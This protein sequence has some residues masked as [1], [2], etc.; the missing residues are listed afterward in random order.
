MIQ[1]PGYSKFSLRSSTDKFHLYYDH[2][3]LTTAIG[4]MDNEKIQYSELKKRVAD[5]ANDFPSLEPSFLMGCFEYFSE[6]DYSYSV[7]GGYS[8]SV[9]DKKINEPA[10][11]IIGYTATTDLIAL[12]ESGLSSVEVFSN[13]RS[14]MYFGGYFWVIDRPDYKGLMWKANSPKEN[15]DYIGVNLYGSWDGKMNYSR[16]PEADNDIENARILQNGNRSDY[17]LT[18]NGEYYLRNYKYTVTDADAKTYVMN[19]AIGDDSFAKESVDCPNDY[20]CFMNSDRTLR[21]IVP[22]A[23]ED[24]KLCDALPYGECF[25][26]ARSSGITIFKKVN[27][28]EWTTRW[29]LDGEL[30]AME[31][32]NKVPLT[33][34]TV[35][36]SSF[37]YEKE[38]GLFTSDHNIK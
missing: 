32:N 9:M 11:G 38:G 28:G 23:G 20:Q 33:S 2:N 37:L 17:G 16:F 12:L 26:E 1:D 10:N 27:P 30:Y 4:Q 35:T 18:D 8:A 29:V 14:I 22:P 13:H 15:W 31:Q 36:W 6:F 5:F 19:Y 21:V 7:E 3:V 24:F 34:A 25:G